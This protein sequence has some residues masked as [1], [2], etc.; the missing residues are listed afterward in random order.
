[1]LNLVRDP[2]TGEPFLLKHGIV[3]FKL[4]A[5]MTNYGLEEGETTL[6]GFT[7]LVAAM[8]KGTSLAFFII[9]L[10]LS[11]TYFPRDS[12]YLRLLPPKKMIGVFK[13]TK[14]ETSSPH[15]VPLLNTIFLW[16]NCVKRLTIGCS[17][18]LL[19]GMAASVLMAGIR[20]GLLT[21]GIC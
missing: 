12:K 17:M 19:F 6:T 7:I 5:V 9:W 13:Q 10:A 2:V 20:T 18:S 11:C 4:A 15:Y 14:T 1:M 21:G 8:L 3:N 16:S